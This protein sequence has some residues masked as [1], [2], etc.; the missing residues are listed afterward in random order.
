MIKA[1]I[2]DMDGVIID[3]E[4]LW[5]EA[6]IHCFNEVGFD[7]SQDKCRKTQGMRLIEVVEYWYNEQPWSGKSIVDVEQ[8]ILQKI[9]ELII[10]KGRKMKGVA[11]SIAH[12]KAKGYK[13]GLASSSAS[14]LINAALT[15]LELTNSFDVINSAENLTLGKPHP[16]IFIKTAK[17]LNVKPS[18][19]LVIEDSFHGVLAGKAALMKVIAIPDEE[20]KDDIRFSIADYKLDNLTEVENI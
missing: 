7:F 19:C 15:K 20:N 2:Y 14:S 10:E 16:E 9:T 5:R 12:F 8:Q 17:Q 4:P 18:N 13:I 11:F 3:S 1:V 6:L